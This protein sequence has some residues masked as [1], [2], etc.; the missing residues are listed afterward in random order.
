VPDLDV[1][2]A[3]V[4]G[5]ED[6]ADPF[7]KVAHLITVADLGGWPVADATFFDSST[8]LVTVLRKG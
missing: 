3:A 6:P 8:G 4:P 1:R 2:A 7:P 5:A